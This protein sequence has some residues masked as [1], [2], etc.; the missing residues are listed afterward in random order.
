[1]RNPA[2]HCAQQQQQR[3]NSSSKQ[4]QQRG[5]TS[6]LY[7]SERGRRRSLLN[8]ISILTSRAV[9]V[10]LLLD[11]LHGCSRRTTR[12]AKERAVSR[13]ARSGLISWLSPRRG[14]GGQGGHQVGWM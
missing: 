10:L 11:V 13:A 1:L 9:G 5:S 7:G 6:C 14:D 3:S 8:V 12:L 4:Q 2:Q